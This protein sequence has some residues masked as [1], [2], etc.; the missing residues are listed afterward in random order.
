MFSNGF[1]TCEAKPPRQRGGAA[2][3]HHV[4]HLVVRRAGEEV[5]QRAADFL[6]Q[7]VHERHE[8]RL[9]I[10]F[11]QIAGQL[12]GLG[13]FERETVPEVEG[14]FVSLD[15]ETGFI[16]AMV[17]G[18]DYDKN[19]FNHVTLAWRQPGSSFKPFIYSAALEKGFTPSTTVNDAPLFFDAADTGSQPWE[20]K[21]YDG[22]FE[23]PMSLRRGLAKSKNMVS[24]RVLQSVGPQFAQDWIT[25]FGFEADKHPPYL[26]MALGAGS[27]TPLQLAAGYGVFA[28]GGHFVRPVLVT[29]LTDTRGNVLREVT[30][31][32]LSDDTKVLSTRNAFVMSSLLQEVMRTGTA[33]AASKA[34]AGRRDIYGK[35]GTTND[36]I[37]AWFAGYHPTLVAVAWIGY[38]TPRKLGDKETGGGLALPVWIDYMQQMLKGV[39]LREIAPPPQGVT[40]QGEGEWSFDEYAQGGGRVLEHGANVA[41]AQLAH[42]AFGQVV[43]APAFE[44][45]FAVR[46]PPGRFQQADDGRAGERFSGARFTHHAED[47]TGGDFERH[48]VQCAQFAAAG[49]EFHLEVAHFEQGRGWQGRLGR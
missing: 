34:L 35:T 13:L 37:D 7:A 47:F 3:Q 1:T 16:R 11:R 45:D 23:G 44:Q 6:R 38:D 30:P 8:D 28:N 5:L 31:P 36:S 26:T 17:G 15:P 18:F 9:L 14:A 33:T 25:R 10:V 40:E 12:F 43:D 2:G 41:A 48:I 20:P 27:T 46:H 22:K 29:R 4:V 42:L 24:I 39:P 19:K 32:P 49:M 21:N